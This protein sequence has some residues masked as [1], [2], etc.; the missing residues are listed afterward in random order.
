MNGARQQSTAI[1]TLRD[2]VTLGPTRALSPQI[3]INDD[4]PVG[5]L[6]Y[7]ALKQFRFQIEPKQ[8]TVTFQ[9]RFSKGKFKLTT[10]GLSAN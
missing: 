7:D 10:L 1:T 4:L 9:P 8:R 3:A 2:A 6:G 5:D